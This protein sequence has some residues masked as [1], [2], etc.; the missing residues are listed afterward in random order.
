MAEQTKKPQS[1]QEKAKSRV[2]ARQATKAA[3]Q[4][5]RGGRELRPDESNIIRRLLLTVSYCE[6]AIKA[7]RNGKGYNKAI[8]QACSDLEIAVT[9]PANDQQ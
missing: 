4:A 6:S 3:E 5:A 2:A 8:T 9:A 1:E 7:I